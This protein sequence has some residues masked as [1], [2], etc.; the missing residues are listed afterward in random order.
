MLD[1]QQV[2]LISFCNSAIRVIFKTIIIMIT[3]KGKVGQ[4][5]SAR[6]PGF[7]TAI[8][9]V[10]PIVAI[11]KV[12]VTVFIMAIVVTSFMIIMQSTAKLIREGDE[13]TA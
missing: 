11:I 12:V 6:L 9:Q 2:I 3:A 7:L 4:Q 13:K 10:E 8:M 1:G 5:I